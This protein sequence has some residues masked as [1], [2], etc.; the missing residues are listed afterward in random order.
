[1]NKAKYLIIIAFYSI[2]GCSA[3]NKCRYTDYKAVEDEPLIRIYTKNMKSGVIEFITK[4]EDKISLTQFSYY[5]DSNN[6]DV[7]CYKS[8]NMILSSTDERLNGLWM[9][10]EMFMHNEKHP[11]KE[12]YWTCFSDDFI[13]VA[14]SEKIKILDELSRRKPD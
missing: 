14:N 5:I 10:T 8:G 4:N 6:K 2:I 9:T 12:A 7:T 11:K 13:D 3:A 1:M